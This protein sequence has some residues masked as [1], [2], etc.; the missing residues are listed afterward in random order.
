MQQIKQNA[1]ILAI[2]AAPTQQKPAAPKLDVRQKLK[3]PKNFN[4][5]RVK[6]KES[7]DEQ[8]KGFTMASIAKIIQTEKKDESDSDGYVETTE[9]EQIAI[10]KN[11]TRLNCEER[12]EYSDEDMPFSKKR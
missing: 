10:V 4:L 5:T 2:E 12:D 8:I 1:P 9:Q 7:F 3:E 11:D 6:P